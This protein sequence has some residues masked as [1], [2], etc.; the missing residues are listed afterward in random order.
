M[1]RPE[2]IPLPVPTSVATG[3]L[4]DVHRFRDKFV[5]FGGTFVATLQLQGTIDG[6]E[7][8][9]IG[10]PVSSPTVIPVSETVQFLQVDVTAFTSGVP[11]ATAAG[12]DFRA[13]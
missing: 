8:F 6:T 1:P 10:G 2:Q 7:F 4:R 9:N 13:I 12:F 11:T 5:Q 3:A